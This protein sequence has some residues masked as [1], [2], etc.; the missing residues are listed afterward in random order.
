MAHSPYSFD[1]PTITPAEHKTHNH[2]APGPAIDKWHRF[3]AQEVSAPQEIAC[4][5]ACSASS[6]PVKHMHPCISLAVH[7]C[8]STANIKQCPSKYVHNKQLGRLERS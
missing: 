2:F 6:S 7:G 4:H 5:D 1:P 8:I 3:Y